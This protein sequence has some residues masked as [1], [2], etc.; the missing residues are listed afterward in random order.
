M[1]VQVKLPWIKSEVEGNIID[2]TFIAEDFKVVIKDTSG[3]DIYGIMD[4]FLGS[5]TG[6][7]NYQLRSTFI[8]GKTQDPSDVLYEGKTYQQLTSSFG[9]LML[10]ADSENI[11]FN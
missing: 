4:G 10:D 8:E 2:F 5:S 11:F 7:Y 1:S 3:P 6:T 9:N